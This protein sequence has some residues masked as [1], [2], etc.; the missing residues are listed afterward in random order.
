MILRTML[1]GSPVSPFITVPGSVEVESVLVPFVTLFE[2]PGFE[3]LAFD[4]LEVDMLPVDEFGFE[5]VS[6]LS[7]VTLG[8]T[9]AIFH[10]MVILSLSISYSMTCYSIF[11]MTIT[12]LLSMTILY[13]AP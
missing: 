11:T 3:V 9:A 2:V 4:E 12:L 1:T 5:E 6:F 10:N 8:E 13:R 7:F